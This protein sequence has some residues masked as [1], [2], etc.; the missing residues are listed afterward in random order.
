MPR[1][2]AVATLL[3]IAVT[4]ASN[5]VS[6][7]VA[8]DEGA[9]VVA[10]VAWRSAFTALFV[11][12][13]IRLQGVPVGLPAALR[14]GVVL[15][16]ALLAVQ[17]YCL[18]SAVARIPAAL[19][20]LAFNTFPILLAL[21]SWGSGGE[22]PSRRAVVAMPLALAG[23]ALALDV[24]GR[25]EEVTGRW[26]EIGEGVSYALA[27]ALAFALVLHFTAHWLKELDG[28]VRAFFTM[29]VTA[30]LVL[31]AGAAS[32]GFALPE[33]SGGWTAFVLLALFYASAFTALFAV[34]PKIGAVNN[35]A[36]LNFEPIALLGMGWVVLGQAVAPRQIVGAF[37]VIGAITLLSLRLRRR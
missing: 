9:S 29:C 27:A 32:G 31:A 30:V 6:A 15:I 12:A 18:Y 22:R 5:H 2:A 1:W 7:R 23:L 14:G 11:L 8:F 3:A 28:R 33:T 16:G 25:F 20:L 10:A 17:S 37:L 26:R 19:A 4:F 13:L 24:V 35:S 21:I 34:L 36:V